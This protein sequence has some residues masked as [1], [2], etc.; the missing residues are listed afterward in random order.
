M[1]HPR[2]Q[3]CRVCGETPRLEVPPGSE[4]EPSEPHVRWWR[5]CECGGCE[6]RFAHPLDFEGASE[7]L[8]GRPPWTRRG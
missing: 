3:D 4:R 2:F 7:R 8:F 1:T 5:A 6:I